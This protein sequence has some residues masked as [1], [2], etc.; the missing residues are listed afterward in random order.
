MQSQSLTQGMAIKQNLL[1]NKAP[2][3]KRSD[4]CSNCHKHAYS[5]ISCPLL[6]TLA[7]SKTVNISISG[8]E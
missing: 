7:K 1:E 4:F 2:D 8:E 6:P 5:K 3:G